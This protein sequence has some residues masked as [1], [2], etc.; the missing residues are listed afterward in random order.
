MVTKI[1]TINGVFYLILNH[2]NAEIRKLFYR[3]NNLIPTWTLDELDNGMKVNSITRK[4]RL[5][6]LQYL[7]HSPNYK[8][9]LPNLKI[10]VIL[11]I[12]LLVILR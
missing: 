7:R 2:Y 8:L 6:L 1:D 11:F 12:Q 5:V 10:P 4:T 9:L 3:Y